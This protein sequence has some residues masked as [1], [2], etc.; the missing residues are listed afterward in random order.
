MS[1]HRNPQIAGHEAVRQVPSN[2]AIERPDFIFLF[3]TVGYDQQT[4]VTVV[5]ALH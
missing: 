3:A 5:A 4:I 1:Y 2:D